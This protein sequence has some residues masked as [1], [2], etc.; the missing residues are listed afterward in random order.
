V[1]SRREVS[2]NSGAPWISHRPL[3]RSLLGR[4]ARRVG[5]RPLPSPPPFPSALDETNLFGETER[6]A[7]RRRARAHGG[8][9]CGWAPRR[10]APSPSPPWPCT[11][12]CAAHGSP[13]GCPAGGWDRRRPRPPPPGRPAGGV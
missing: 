12:S 1:R 4:A 6:T 5:H 13:P 7:A 10:P 9:T 3:T 2:R 8:S 11:G